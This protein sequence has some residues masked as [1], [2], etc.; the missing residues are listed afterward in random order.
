MKRG[1]RWACF[2]SNTL[3][4]WLFLLHLCLINFVGCEI[5]FE[6]NMLSFIYNS[7]RNFNFRFMIWNDFFLFFLFSWWL[8]VS[9]IKVHFLFANESYIILVHSNIDIRL[10]FFRQWNNFWK[11]FRLNYILQK[12][13]FNLLLILVLFFVLLHGH[14]NAHLTLSNSCIP[15]NCMCW[16]YT[17]LTILILLIYIKF[18]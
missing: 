12:W 3:S 18:Q 11:R 6:K 7:I 4:V 9:G 8:V 17:F 16:L 15:Q 5:L 1:R 2:V 10:L 13:F 14:T